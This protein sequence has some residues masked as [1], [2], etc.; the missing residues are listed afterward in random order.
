MLDDTFFRSPFLR[1]K[2]P[3]VLFTNGTSGFDRFFRDFGA[4]R[5]AR[6]SFFNEAD[7]DYDSEGP[8]T[9]TQFSNS[10]DGKTN[11]FGFFQGSSRAKADSE[12]TQPNGGVIRNIPIRIEGHFQQPQKFRAEPQQPAF[13]HFQ[14]PHFASVSASIQTPG[15]NSS[16]NSYSVPGYHRQTS[17][18]ILK[19]DDSDTVSFRSFQF[20]SEER[21]SNYSKRSQ[22][23]GRGSPPQPPQR[24][25]FSYL[26]KQHQRPTSESFENQRPGASSPSPSVPSFKS[27][28][29]RSTTPGGMGQKTRPKSPSL[30]SLRNG[31][32][33]ATNCVRRPLG[34]SDS[35]YEISQEH[36]SSNNSNFSTPV[37]QSV[38]SLYAT[39]NK[40]EKRETSPVKK[41]E[42]E[43]DAVEEA[44]RSLESF[45]PNKILAEAANE[46]LLR[47][48]A[49]SKGSSSD[50]DSG[51][52][53]IRPEVKKRNSE[54]PTSSGIV[55]DINDSVL[56]S[57]ELSHR[58]SNGS[59]NENASLSSS[60]ND[61]GSYILVDPAMHRFQ[62]PAVPQPSTLPQT[63][64]LPQPP[65]V[66]RIA[67]SGT[68]GAAPQRAI[69]STPSSSN[70]TLTRNSNEGPTFDS[71]SGSKT[72]PPV[73]AII[74]EDPVGSAEE[75]DAAAMRKR[76]L[77]AQMTDCAKVIEINGLKMN[78]FTSTPNWR[79][80]HLLQ[81]N[82]PMVQDT[83]YI[84]EAALDELLEFT[85]R[86]S[87]MRGDPKNDEFIQLVAPLRTSQALIHRIRANLDATQWTL[88]A[89]ARMHHSMVSNDS[90]DQFVAIMQQLP[91]DC[92]KVVQWVYLL[93]TPSQGGANFL[94]R[95]SPGAV[96][97][98]VSTPIPEQMRG[99]QEVSKVPQV[100]RK[101]PEKLQ[102][103]SI[104]KQENRA[105]P[106][107]QFKATSPLPQL[108]PPTMEEI[109][110][111]GGESTT[112]STGSSGAT[113]V[114]GASPISPTTPTIE[115]KTEIVEEDDLSSIADGKQVYEEDD[116]MSVISES[117]LYQDYSLVDN[118]SLP[119]AIRPKKTTL[120][121]P[122]ISPALLKDLSEEERE[123][124]KFYAPQLETHTSG[125]CKLIDEFFNVIE[126]NQEPSKFVQ[127]VRLIILEAQ[128]LVYIG[129]NMAQC[130]AKPILR[131]EFR[132]ASD[133]LNGL[134]TECVSNAR[135]A[136]DQ[137]P[138]VQPVQAMMNSVVAVSDAAQGLK[139]LG[140]VCA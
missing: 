70:S 83:M 92:R 76:I 135:L 29:E 13:S 89:L 97:F 3:P 74:T 2:L 4:P 18:P 68:F 133:K 126:H 53:I 26:L 24:R 56:K 121:L 33:K 32:R 31:L 136:K 116:L 30:Q 10:A 117:S 59:S 9:P 17:Q 125:L 38:S 27:E 12:A 113:D 41:R 71:S 36:R 123:L 111:D 115:Q 100:E 43:Y 138:S 48:S 77:C 99:Q 107:S 79:Y 118:G 61:A 103:R 73:P 19:S 114:P 47:V 65:A 57:S 75:E 87:I 54:S 37:N 102:P 64:A 34:S 81:R 23:S 93:G 72:L 90:L 58:S 11:G 137:Y 98:P 140:K 25:A 101:I 84:I 60:D 108:Q 120:Q 127:K 80:P 35:D 132:R 85:Q 62:P 15:P 44:I 86:I 78:Q 96:P 91:K 42:E 20:P 55:A 124:L 22:S 16:S 6:E 8:P 69:V 106:L 88:H 28:R 5:S 63:S 104:K 7:D 40:P 52:V 14:T 50:S 21:A 46:R 51:S 45:D 130:V 39:I 67:H 49:A 139:H 66:S 131:A 82:L 129:D 122:K 94:P 134:L 119:K 1:E 110:M 128:T 95:H 109:A 105:S 112:S